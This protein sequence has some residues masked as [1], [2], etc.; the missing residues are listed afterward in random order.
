[1]QPHTRA[2]I[3]ELYR[4]CQEW[5]SCLHMFR[6]LVELPVEDIIRSDTAVMMSNFVVVYFFYWDYRMTIYILT[7]YYL[8]E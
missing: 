6:H 4:S 7:V 3:Q 8:L 1:M 2:T 5:V